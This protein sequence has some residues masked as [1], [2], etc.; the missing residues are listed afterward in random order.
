MREII[1]ALSGKKYFKSLGHRDL[2]L[3]FVDRS[4]KSWPSWARY[5][6]FIGLGISCKTPF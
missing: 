4:R 2:H 3:G 5:E 1:M 6:Y